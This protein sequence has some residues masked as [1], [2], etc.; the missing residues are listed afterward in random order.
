M[1]LHKPSWFKRNKIMVCTAP[2]CGL[3]KGGRMLPLVDPATGARI[4]EKDPETDEMV[5]AVND[6]LLTDMTALRNSKTTDTLRFI[7]KDDVSMRTAVPVFYDRRFDEAFEAAM[8]SKRFAGF[9]SA[10][11]AELIDDKLITIHGGHGSPSADQRVGDVPYIKV[12]D[13]RAGLV[14]INPTN[15]VPHQIAE[16]HWRGKKSG[17]RAFDLL[18]PERTSKNIGDF[19]VLMP[20]QERVLLTKEI[21]VMRP[22]PEAHFDAF[23]LLWAMTLKIVREQ[24]KRVIFMQT[25]REDVG[26]RYLDI[27][28]PIAKKAATA[29]EAAAAFRAYYTTLARARTQLAEYLSESSEHHFFVSGAEAPPPDEVAA[30]EAEGEAALEV[31]E[32][33]DE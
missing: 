12:S 4:Q 9:T 15:R 13:L 21:I 6:K 26:D 31:E 20:G 18:S 19:C 23:F 24:W 16:K 10:T 2:T 28:I 22:G 1:S 30:A 8:T 5:D 32:E 33:D 3:T 27:S 7:D 25:N 29:T 11:L 17:L 14:N